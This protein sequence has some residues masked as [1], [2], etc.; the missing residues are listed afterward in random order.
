MIADELSIKILHIYNSLH[1][2]L[3]QLNY[4]SMLRVRWII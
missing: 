2:N 3:V 1:Q 4:F